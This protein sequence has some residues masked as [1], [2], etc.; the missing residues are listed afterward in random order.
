MTNSQTVQLFNGQAADTVGTETGFE[1]PFSSERCDIEVSGDF[2]SGGTVTIERLSND[3][4]TWVA[5]RDLSRVVVSVTTK[6]IIPFELPYNVT[7]RAQ[8]SGSTS[9][10]LNVWVNLI[11]HGK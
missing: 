7:L 2:G 9:P 6:E 8:L 1:I 4:S 11:R 5:E 3:G 10:D